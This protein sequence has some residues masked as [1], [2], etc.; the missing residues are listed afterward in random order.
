MLHQNQTPRR[1]R[2]KVGNN[3]MARYTITYSC[4][5]TED[6]QLFGKI[7]DRDKYLNW[8][9]EHKLCPEC[10]RAEQTRKATEEASALNL[11][12]LTGSEKQIAWAITIRSKVLALIDE[13]IK[14][15]DKYKAHPDYDRFLSAWA[16]LK[17][18]IVANTSAK[19]YIDTFKGVTKETMR[20]MAAEYF[21]SNGYM[22]K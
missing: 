22:R 4:G 14:D 19:Y 2:D 11:A 16:A 10:Q 21:K 18:E 7:D 3:I 12:E 6:K 8:C 9:K 15:A 13:F 1:Q 5:H 17:A 20:M